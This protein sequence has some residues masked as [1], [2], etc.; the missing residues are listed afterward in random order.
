MRRLSIKRITRSQRGFSLTEVVIAMAAFGIVGASIMGAL[1]ASNKTIISS[2]EATVA[3][4]LTR[5]VIEYVKR[6]PYD[7]TNFPTAYYDS[8][9]LGEVVP[10][11]VDYATLLT[12]DGDPYYGNYA[13]DVDIERLD[14][15]ADGTG[16]D[17]GIQKVTVEIKYRGKQA[18]TT[19]DYKVKR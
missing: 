11:A 15:E 9:A 19:A 18:L 6:S 16:D 3:E 1:S 2:H 10:G 5:T 17:D 12:L 8:E 14:R 4:S 7:S 13:V